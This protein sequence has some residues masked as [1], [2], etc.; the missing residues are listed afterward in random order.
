MSSDERR[1][2]EAGAEK[3]ISQVPAF[4]SPGYSILH[5]VCDAQPRPDGAVSCGD[6]LNL[7]EIVR[8]TLYW[9][10]MITF[11]TDQ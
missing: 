6:H 5:L 10:V 4:P 1:N 9:S 7:G 11:I 8:S 3:L 2:N